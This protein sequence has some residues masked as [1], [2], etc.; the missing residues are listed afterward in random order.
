MFLITLFLV[1][2]TH[3]A[4]GEELEKPTKLKKGGAVTEFV[5]ED[6]FKL[7][8]AALE[9]LNIEFKSL[10]TG[11]KWIVP[12]TSLVRIKNSVG[13]YRRYDGWITMVLVTVLEKN[14]KMVSIKSVDLQ[15]GDDVATSG[16][17]FLR[18]TDVDLNSDTVDACSH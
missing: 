15:A 9:N 8:Q 11:N 5:K 14:K 4:I 17:T 6:G 16:V 3:V 18:M 13:V 12:D 1:S 10:P 7:T 2:N